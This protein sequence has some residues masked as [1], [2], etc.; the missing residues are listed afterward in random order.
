MGTFNGP[1]PLRTKAF[2]LTNAEILTLFSVGADIL[3]APGAGLF[4][5]LWHYAFIVDSAA[6]A[7]VG[8]GNASWNWGSA[9]A[10]VAGLT[11][12]S[13]TAGAIVRAVN[14]Q[15][16]VN[17]TVSP[18]NGALRLVTATADFT[19]GNAANT[20]AGKIWY[21]IEQATQPFL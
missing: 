18:T 9:T 16:M 15:T 3:P 21:T 14:N 10:S 19:G 2:V 12:A 8:G 20:L 1:Q 4:I 6:G 7:Y 13:F 11:S 5:H 17:L